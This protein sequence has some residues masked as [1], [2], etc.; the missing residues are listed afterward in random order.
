MKKLFAVLLILVLVGL[1]ACMPPAE[2][3]DQEE[4]G[5]EAAADEVSEDLD[6]VLTV[7]EDLDTS[8]MDTLD[9]DLAEITW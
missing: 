4:T 2:M 5:T 9:Q 1:V 6:A 8:S 7:E 3:L